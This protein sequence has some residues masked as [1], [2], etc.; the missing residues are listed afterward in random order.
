LYSSTNINRVI[1]SRR[2]RWGGNLAYIT[3]GNVYIK[4]M[5]KKP[6]RALGRPWHRWE[7][8]IKMNLKE[9]GWES[10]LRLIGS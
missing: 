5:V 3:E 6:E 4:M 10:G 2:M 1:K 7:D 8:I 9:I